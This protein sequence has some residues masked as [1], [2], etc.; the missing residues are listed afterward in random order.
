MPL[1]ILGM[2]IGYEAVFFHNRHINNSINLAT[3][4]IQSVNTQFRKCRRTH[5]TYKFNG[6]TN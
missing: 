6:V 2:D 3:G 1:Q 5:F 4:G